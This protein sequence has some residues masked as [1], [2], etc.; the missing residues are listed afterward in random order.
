MIA[1][2]HFQFTPKCRYFNCKHNITYR[3]RII[4][5]VKGWCNH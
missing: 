1:R 2:N 4:Y 3:I 5:L